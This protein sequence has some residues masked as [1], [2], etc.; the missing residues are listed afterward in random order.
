M[1]TSSTDITRRGFVAGA[2]A[3]A[4][5]A[6]LAGAG[7]A[8]AEEAAVMTP[9]TYTGQAVGYAGTIVVD[10]TVSETAI[11]SIEVVDNI[12]QPST[13]IPSEDE[14]PFAHY[15]WMV[16]SDTLRSSRP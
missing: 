14:D 10:V 13:I 12:Q 6:A 8:L 16:R 9:G 3:V 5:G 15:A 1:S 11:E 2:T 7:T 4:A